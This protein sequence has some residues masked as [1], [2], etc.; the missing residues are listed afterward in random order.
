MSTEGGISKY[1]KYL[2]RFLC[3]VFGHDW[4]RDK[5]VIIC[6]HSPTVVCP[7]WTWSCRRKGCEITDMGEYRGPVNDKCKGTMGPN[8]CQAI[9]K[10]MNPKK[11]LGV[12]YSPEVVDKLC[13]ISGALIV[14]TII[15]ILI[16]ILT[17]I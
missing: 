17:V 10:G 11:V 15:L 6:P 4:R 16:G 3:F 12:K 8:H 14:L 7:H 2:D 5:H 1:Q 13:I 9:N